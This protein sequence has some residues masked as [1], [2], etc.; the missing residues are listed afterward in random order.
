M[1]ATDGV[2][3]LE[4]LMSIGNRLRKL[5]TEKRL[6]LSQVAKYVGVPV[7]TYRDW[8]YGKSI[9]GEP[10]EKLAELFE[11]SLVELM[12]GKKSQSAS[13]ISLL[14]EVKRDVETAIKVAQTL[15]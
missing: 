13:V 7:S 3:T 2:L 14:L 8:E 4:L 10:Y 1:H 12:T 11:V 5:R 15:S 6:T 9:R